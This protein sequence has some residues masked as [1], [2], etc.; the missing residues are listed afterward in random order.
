[1]KF[2][3]LHQESYSRGQLLLRMFFG[4]FYIAIPHFFVL[5][6]LSFISGIITFIAFWAILF[7][8]KYPTGMFSFQVNYMKWTYRVIARLMNLADGYPK[9]GLNAEDSILVFDIPNPES[10]SRGLLLL[11]VFFG[12]IYVLIPHGFIL[13]FR[14]IGTMVLMF[15]AFWVVLFT[16]NYPENWHKFNVGTFRWALRINFYMNFMTDVYPPFTGK[17]IE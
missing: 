9:F 17:E 14:M 5:M 13:Y 3:I 7:T 2:D 8:G 10:L 11:K 12:F 4:Y 15:L 1:M 16:G 6:F